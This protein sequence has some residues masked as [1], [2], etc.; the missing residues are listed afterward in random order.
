MSKSTILE[1]LK[2]CR[3]YV[4]GDESHVEVVDVPLPVKIE[5]N[6]ATIKSLRHQIG[7]PQSGLANLVGVSKR[8]VE[9][10]ESDRSEPNKSAR[11]LLALLMQDNSLADKL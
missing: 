7:T 8:T 3:D 2:V 6:A 1:S 11:K 9:A 10:W 5:F 4:N